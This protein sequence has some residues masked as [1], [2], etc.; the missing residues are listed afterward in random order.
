[1]K[2]E[3]LKKLRE[4][5][6][7]LTKKA[8]KESVNDDNLISQTI[9][10][11]EDA[12]RVANTLVKRLRE[13]SGLYVPEVS[14]AVESHETF[15]ELLLTKNRDELLKQFVVKDS[16]GADLNK[17][18]VEA[19]LRLAKQAQSLYKYK[20]DQEKYLEALM[21]KYCPN[22]QYLAG[23]LIGAKLLEHAG[24]L[25]RL[26]L[27]PAS[28]IQLLGA[29]KALFRHMKTGSRCPR[30]GLIVTHSFVGVATK[31][32]RGK[33]SR[34]LADKISI[35]VKVDYYKGEFVGDDLKK[36]LDSKFS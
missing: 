36:Q 34:A 6:L 10:S 21:K 24:S 30:H 11:I 31:N 8:V 33:R 17:K 16:M 32:E 27:M 20:Q 19:M 25:Y 1:M 12:D 2:K 28:T 29:E 5:N 13:W 18:D 9:N 23:T 15:V 22:L 4:K 14:K 7:E 3:N 35:A 26:V